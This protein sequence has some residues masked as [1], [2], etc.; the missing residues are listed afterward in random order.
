MR[1][2]RLFQIADARGIRYKWIAGQLGYTPEYLSR[3]KHGDEPVTDEFQRRV[4][5]LF[6]DVAPEE[7]FFVDGGST[8][9]RSVPSGTKR[10]A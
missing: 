7:L 4:C 10:V 3:I 1:K 8:K 5:V 9:N 2:T 6:P